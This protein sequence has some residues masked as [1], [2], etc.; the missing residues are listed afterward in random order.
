MEVPQPHRAA[1]VSGRARQPASAMPCQR[2]TCSELLCKEALRRLPHPTVTALPVL[3]CLQHPPVVLLPLFPHLSLLACL[4]IPTAPLLPPMAAAGAATLYLMGGT[5]LW[6]C[7]A[8][9]H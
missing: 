1:L 8:W 7:P 6:T 2:V 3:A 4:P 5:T 9:C